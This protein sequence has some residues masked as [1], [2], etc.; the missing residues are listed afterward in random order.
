MHQKVRV[1]ITRVGTWT[2]NSAIGYAITGGQDAVINIFNLQHPR[3]EPDF[4][5]IGHSDN[6]CTLD[7]TPAGTI[8]SGSWD[9]LRDVPRNWNDGTDIVF[10]RTAKVWKNHTVVHDLKGH[11][12]SVWAVLGMDENQYLTGQWE[13][14]PFFPE[15]FTLF[16][17]ETYYL[18]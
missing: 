17:S 12:Q 18:F 11:Q 3:N 6:I 7:V 4:C 8:I 10:C 1:R 15:I 2:L 5:L 9:K 14:L 13:L 16:S